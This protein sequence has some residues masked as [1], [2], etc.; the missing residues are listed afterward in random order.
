[1][2]IFSKIIA[3]IGLFMLYGLLNQLVLMSSGRTSGPSGA[4][5]TILALGFFAG[6][7]A[8]WRSKSPKASDSDKLDKSSK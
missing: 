6:V 2:T 1:M 3:S 4:V 7:V 8:I 5:G